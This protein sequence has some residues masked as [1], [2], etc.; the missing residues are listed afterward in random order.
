MVAEL[1]AAIA[2]LSGDPLLLAVILFAATFLLEDAATVA[3]GGIVA[4]SNADT[5][6][7]L[8]AVILGTAIGDIA[9]YGVGRWG[10]STRLGASLRRRTDVRRAE[11]WI[12]GRTLLL[13][14]GARF[15]PGTRLPIYS[16][17]GFI[18]APA[19]PVIAIIALTTPLWTSALFFVAH[20]AGEA[21]ATVFTIVMLG[22]GALLVAA[23][24]LFKPKSKFPNQKITDGECY[25]C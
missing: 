8:A 24:V 17:S 16:A 13:V 7:M 19:M 5:G 14:F 6:I 12:A 22:I 11:K 25:E 2:S 3:A 1:S 20:A 10:S 4:H 18:A 15:L 9:L 21:G 23:T